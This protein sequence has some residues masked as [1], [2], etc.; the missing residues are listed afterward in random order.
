VKG[1]LIGGGRLEGGLELEKEGEVGE[2][3]EG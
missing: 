1:A 2:D 3:L